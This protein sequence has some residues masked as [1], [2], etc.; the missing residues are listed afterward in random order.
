MWMP[1]RASVPLGPK[2]SSASGTSSPAGAKMMAESRGTG[3]GSNAPPTD[4]APS[5]RASSRAC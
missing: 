4:A 1:A 5:W 3:A 2:D